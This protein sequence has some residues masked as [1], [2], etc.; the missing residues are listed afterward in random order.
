MSE[1]YIFNNKVNRSNPLKYYLAAAFSALI[2]FQS[3][4]QE[5]PVVLI[6]PSVAKSSVYQHQLMDINFKR[7]QSGAGQA[8]LQFDN[9][10]YQLQLNN[11]GDALILV[12]PNVK[13]GN[14]QL[15][16][17]DVADSECR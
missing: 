17:L 16:K 10:D 3:L 6:D 2:T 11:S 13:L 9:E 4:S 7:L 14:E 12:L 15:F 1:R 8:T 5:A